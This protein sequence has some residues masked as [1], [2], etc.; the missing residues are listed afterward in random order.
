MIYMIWIISSA[1]SM[2]PN[3]SINTNKY[4]VPIFKDEGKE[5]INELRKYDPSQIASLMNIS[6]RLSELNVVRY[7][8]WDE[9]HKLSNSKQ[10]ISLY[11]GDVYK[12]I[13]SETL[14]NEQLNFMNKHLRIISGLYGVL[15]P[16]DIIQPYRLEMSIKLKNSKGNDLYDFWKDK[17]T[18]YFNEEIKEQKDKFIINLASKEYVKAIDL[19]KLKARVINIVFKEYRNG[20]YKVVPFNAKR[21]RGS[22]V[23]Y[24]TE[25]FVEDVENIKSFDVDYKYNEKMSTDTDWVFIKDEFFCKKY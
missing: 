18:A 13:D 20:R 9:N 22:F 6:D 11:N 8:K 17:I 21:A 7:D 16:L 10:A 24:M 4:T 23:R 25:N 14:N 3:K 5:L 2:N 19:D 15:R 1:K 12:K